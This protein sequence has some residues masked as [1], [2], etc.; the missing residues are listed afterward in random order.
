MSAS[1]RAL[2]ALTLSAAVLLP[3]HAAAALP[4]VDPTPAPGSASSS[5]APGAQATSKPVVS[6]ADGATAL[7]KVATKGWVL[8]DLD[9]GEILA[10]Q[11]Q[12]R[13]LRPASTL[14]LLTAL[15]VAPRLAP[16]H[17]ANRRT[18]LKSE[19]VHFDESVLLTGHPG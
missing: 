14:K 4:T 11:D 17:E 18:I 2:A 8:A 10:M 13:K 3:A 9:T 6:A 16:A 15:T 12:D 7:P 5:A 1:S 19:G